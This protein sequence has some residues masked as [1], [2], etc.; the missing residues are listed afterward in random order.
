LVVKNTQWKALANRV[1][2][3]TG[4]H[5]RPPQSAAYAAAW[6]MAHGACQRE[7]AFTMRSEPVSLL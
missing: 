7:T 2:I 6:L 1:V 3:V 4:R 5:P